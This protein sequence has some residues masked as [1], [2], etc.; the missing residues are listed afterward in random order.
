MQKMYRDFRPNPPWLRAILKAL[1]RAA[2]WLL[3]DYSIEGRENIPKEG[4]FLVVANHF[5]FTDP[6]FVVELLPYQAE[7]MAGAAPLHAPAWA[8]LLP[9]LYGV[10]PVHRGSSS[11]DGLRIAEE[12]LKNGG[13]VAIFPEAGSWAQVLRPARPGTS[14]LA[15][16]AAVPILPVGIQGSHNIFPALGKFKR[17][18]VHIKVGEP[19]GPYTA[20]GRGRERREQLDQISQAIMEHIAALI[21][22]ERRGSYSDDP[23][24]RAAAKEFELYPWDELAEGEVEAFGEKI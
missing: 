1:I 2:L 21:P 9:K 24:I 15:S 3:T 18:K 8:R 16:R 6:V 5:S 19:F 12:I 10:I 23:I 4:G 14:F 13:V 11:R 20:G 7:F 22:A 17:A